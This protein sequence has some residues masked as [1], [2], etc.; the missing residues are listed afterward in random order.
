ML[1]QFSF[2]TVSQLDAL[3]TQQQNAPFSYPRTNEKLK[4]Y[5]YD[6]NCT[7]LGEGAN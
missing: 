5:D 7:C 4:G 1:F 6:D 2:P 3:I